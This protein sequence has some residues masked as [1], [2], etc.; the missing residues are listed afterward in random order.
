MNDSNLPSFAPRAPQAPAYDM[1]GMDALMAQLANPSAGIVAGPNA[2][3]GDDS[4]RRAME[5]IAALRNGG[6]L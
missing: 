6:A 3:I 2:N 5:M 1:A 4:R